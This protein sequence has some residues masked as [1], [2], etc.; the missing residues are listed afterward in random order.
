MDIV[1]ETRSLR[2]ELVTL[3]ARPEWDL[4]ARH[5][6]LGGKPPPSF[7]DRVYRLARQALAVLGLLPPRL[8]RYAWRPALKHA[9]L[10]PQARTLLVWAPGMRRE[11]LR[12]ACNGIAARLRDD[13]ALAPVLVTEVADFAYFSRL[14]WL[15][16][17]LPELS[18]DGASYRERKRRH[19]AWC[20]RDA[21]VVPASAG[22][23]SEAQWRALM[24][25]SDR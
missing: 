11:E 12:L 19:L 22:L 24:E 1:E 15:V 14:G 16:E 9:P 23:A 20:Y 10:A 8:T 5:D 7:A 4:L 6:L 17:Y 18:G 3:A 13:C 25:E 21:L 2:R